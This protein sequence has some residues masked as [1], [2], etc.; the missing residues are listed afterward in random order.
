MTGREEHADPLAR[1]RARLHGNGL[2]A[3][4]AD[5]PA[6][7]ALVSSDLVFQGPER[8]LAVLRPVTV[9][10]VQALALIC[11]ELGLSVEVRGAGLSYSAGY[12]T[13]KPDSVVFDMTALR[14]IHAHAGS[15]HV[16]CVEAG[17]TWQALD[18]WLSPTGKR[19]SP[20]APISG[21]RSTIAASIRQG[22]PGDMSGVLAL[23]IVTAEGRLLRTGAL[24][25]DVDF[26]PL[27]RGQG[28][29]LTGLFVGDCGAFGI[30]T[31]AWIRLQRVPEH[32]AFFSC[33]LPQPEHFRSL[34]LGIAAPP[35]AMRAYC[36]DPSRGKSLR[37]QPWRERTQVAMRV[38]A[39]QRGVGAR[40]RG[41]SDLALTAL[42]LGS[43]DPGDCWAAHFCFEADSPGLVNALLGRA[44]SFSRAQGWAPLATTVAEALATRPYSVRGVLGPRY[45]RWAPVSAVFDLSRAEGVLREVA[46]KL[47]DCCGAADVP[48]LRGSFLALSTGGDHLVLEP[49]F[50]WPS[51]LYP[52]HREIVPRAEVEACADADRRD[53]AVQS[54]RS[55]LAR[56]MDQRGGQHVQ[57][58]RFYDYAGR[59]D[60][61]QL[62]LLETLKG[63]LDPGGRIAGGTLGIGAAGLSQ[64]RQAGDGAAPSRSG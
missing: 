60:P 1:L 48:G 28:P 30:L 31:R 47:H 19:P 53:R 56:D 51:A 14:G 4:L 58:G 35:G 13:Q 49:M 8:P 22:M 59:V 21:S 24:A 54:L 64:R 43:G 7:L 34:L 23:E 3:L 63:Y 57:L 46:A 20:H 55:E 32:R 16:V 25:T 33:A 52:L 15:D 6:T 45:E 38:L 40:L 50:L 62:A 26:S 44:R 36:F 9:A 12:L 42:S 39:G 17:V 27:W 37:A 10:D 5:D 41:L 29:D 18:D 11:A 61:A 2:A